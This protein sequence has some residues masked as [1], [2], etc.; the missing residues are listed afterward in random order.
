MRRRGFTLVELLVT[1]TIIG[2]LAS[3]LLGVL[4]M[5]AD[6]ARD[7]R[8]RTMVTR[9]EQAI[10]TR[11]GSYPTRRLPIDP[12]VVTAA[13]G[14]FGYAVD[15][16][17]FAVA[18]ARLVSLR[19]LQRLEL[20]EAWE[21]VT[22]DASAHPTAPPVVMA[23]LPDQ[24]ALSRAYLQRF[25][26]NVHPVTGSPLVP[27][28]LHQGAECLY[29][30]VTMGGQGDDAEAASAFRSADVG[31]VD[32]DGM[33]EFVDGWG[34]PISF[35]RW[36]PG[37]VSE[38]QPDADLATSGIQRDSMNNH[39]AFDPL[40]IDMPPTPGALPNRGWR[41]FPLVYSAG[42][43]GQLDIA[44]G[45]TDPNDPYAANASGLYA[46]EPQDGFTDGLSHLDNITNHSLAG[47]VR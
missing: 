37:F 11:W 36:A 4:A 26:E 21:D 42:V 38:L 47:Q 29:L 16:I 15:E 20:P 23:Y 33:P 7:A 18:A 27:S 1:I 35:L 43:D 28:D 24:P 31:D 46:G 45:S 19:E 9:L 14:N 25:N 44:T 30:I 32:E 6:K 10:T 40:K 8:T 17:P 13:N 5:S 34:V 12:E 22:S 41:M 3:L 2:M 39:D